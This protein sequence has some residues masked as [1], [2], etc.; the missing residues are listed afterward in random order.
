MF[1]VAGSQIAILSCA[2]QD[3]NE[4]A[5]TGTPVL[6]PEPTATPEPTQVGPIADK[7]TGLLLMQLDLR[8]QQIT[9]PG[10]EILA[11]MEEMG[12]RT[13]PVDMQPSFLYFSHKPGKAVIEEMESLGIE[14][15]PDR[16]IPPAS[17]DAYGF[18]QADVPV[19]SFDELA[20]KPYIVRLDTAERVSRPDEPFLPGSEEPTRIDL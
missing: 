2:S 17:N 8:K 6:S 10:E 9:D 20:G 19:N 15:D 16:W 12:M 14:L 3:A 11:R 4:V 7:A 5:T 13:D 1:L 18:L